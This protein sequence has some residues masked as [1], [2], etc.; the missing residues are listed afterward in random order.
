MKEEPEDFKK[1]ARGL[2]SQ[3]LLGK[4]APEAGLRMRAL[5]LAQTCSAFVRATC[6]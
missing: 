3:G 4:R 2:E 6:M 1:T 5:P